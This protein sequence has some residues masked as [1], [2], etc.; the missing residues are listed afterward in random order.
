MQKSREVDDMMNLAHNGLQRQ[1][2]PLELLLRRPETGKAREKG[3]LRF[4]ANGLCWTFQRHARLWCFGG[5]SISWFG[6][7]IPE[8]HR[9]ERPCFPPIFLRF[10]V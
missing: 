6:Q 8:G 1:L 2:S 10:R 3:N 5:L 7:F 9:E 4:H